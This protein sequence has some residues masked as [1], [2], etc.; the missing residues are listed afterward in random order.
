MVYRSL[1]YC[2]VYLTEISFDPGLHCRIL[3]ST[4]FQNSMSRL[5]TY[6]HRGLSESSFKTEDRLCQVTLNILELKPINILR[7]S[8]GSESS[9]QDVESESIGVSLM[10]CSTSVEY[11]A[12]AIS[13]WI[14]N[15]VMLSKL[16]NNTRVFLD[17]LV[18][19]IRVCSIPDIENDSCQ[20]VKD[21]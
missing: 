16:G 12:N 9:N 5:V 14:L 4:L 6:H 21:A 19:G 20:L 18:G 2:A 8:G 7:S 10:R 1:Q 13:K 3:L 15:E 17:K 11:W